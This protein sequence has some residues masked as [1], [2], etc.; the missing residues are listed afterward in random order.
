MPSLHNEG[1]ILELSDQETSENDMS[2]IN[3]FRVIY[4][5]SESF[6]KAVDARLSSLTSYC[7][8]AS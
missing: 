3:V 1:E 7:S 5:S 2:L 4:V 6:N 8:L